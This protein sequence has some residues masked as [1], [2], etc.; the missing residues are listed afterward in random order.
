MSAGWIKL[1]RSL[2]D[3]E[4]YNDDNTFRVFMHLLLCANYEDKQWQGKTI[5]RGQIVIGV[6]KFGLEIGLKKQQTRRALRNIQS[7]GE[8]TLKTTNKYTLV[9][10]E[11]YDFFQKRDEDATHKT[12]HKEHPEQHSNNTQDDTQ[13]TTTKEVKKVRNKELKTIIDFSVLNF[14]DFQIA[15]LKRIKLKNS[16]NK[17][18]SELTQRMVNS[19]AKDFA[20]VHLFGYTIDDALTEWESRGWQGFNPEWLTPKTNL[21]GGSGRTKD[22]TISDRLNDGSWSKNTKTRDRTINEQLN[23]RTWAD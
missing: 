9:S 21:T 23:D 14:T 18:Q 13:T 11:K 19:L 8:I 3:W 7:T 20:R 1:H 6:E 5:K 17:K 4:G 10:I 16:K 15:E 2:V 12:T 22:R